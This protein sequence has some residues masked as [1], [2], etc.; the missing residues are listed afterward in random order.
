MIA[1]GSGVAGSGVFGSG[2]VGSGASRWVALGRVVRPHGVHGALLLAAY[3]EDPVAVLAFQ[4]AGLELRA[5]DGLNR[6]PVEGLRGRMINR[7]LVIAIKGLI[8]R[9][10]AATCRGWILAAPR[11]LLPPPRPDEVYWADLLGLAVFTPL[12]RPLGRIER[13][14]E[15][16]GHLLLAV[17]NPDE[18]GRERLLPF[19]E[20]FLA[21]LDLSGG[22]VV[23]DPPPGLLDL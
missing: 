6:R 20:Q 4:G 8:T 16:G 22:R 1:S 21:E 23:Y 7:R 15:T 11:D 17:A 5:P 2:V 3:T 13:L 14:T 12:G 9:E 18:A 10:A 19:H